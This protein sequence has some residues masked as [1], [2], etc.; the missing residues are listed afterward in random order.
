MHLSLP[1]SLLISNVGNWK[2]PDDPCL[3]R[4]Y[5]DDP[6]ACDLSDLMVVK[7]IISGCKDIIA[8]F[9]ANKLGVDVNIGIFRSGL[10]AHVL[11]F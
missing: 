7:N 1:S 6:D 8:L 10:S 11:G 3:E 2:L 9:F 5:Q 4:T